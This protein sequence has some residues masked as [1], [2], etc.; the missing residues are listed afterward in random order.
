MQHPVAF[1]SI[2]RIKLPRMAL[3]AKNHTGC[4]ILQE[5]TTSPMVPA[6][7]RTKGR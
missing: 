1:S 4:Y 2:K 6:W 7:Y 5:R 3:M